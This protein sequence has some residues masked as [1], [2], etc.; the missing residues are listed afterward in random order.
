MALILNAARQLAAGFVDLLMP[1]L[2]VACKAPIARAGLYCHDCFA[3][4]PLLPDPLCNSCGHPLPIEQA[5]DSQCLSCLREPPPY[6]HARAAYFYDGPA[7]DTVLALKHGKEAL[8]PLMAQAMARAAGPLLNE[9]MLV[10]P[11]PLHRWRLM[12]RGFNQALLL[13]RPIAER[14][15]ATLVPQ[16]LIRTRATARSVGMSVSARRRNVAGA[17]AV[18]PQ[19][20]EKLQGAEVLLVDDVLTSGATLEG[21]TKVLLKAGAQS[22]DV[23]VFARVAAA[24]RAH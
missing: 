12:D 15:G 16:L 23:L 19:T 24:T 21:C 14:V 3:E 20:Q 4:L 5:A 10:A 18:S 8:A 1:P 6:R 9:N 11:V 2:C 17:F 13:A 22:V 7:R